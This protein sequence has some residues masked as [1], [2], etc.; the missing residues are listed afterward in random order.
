LNPEVRG[1]KI[2]KFEKAGFQGKGRV[3]T[4]KE[5]DSK[6]LWGLEGKILHGDQ[7]LLKLKGSRRE[8]VSTL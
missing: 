6:T 4:G 5:M 8:K 7:R 3:M 2:A 1:K